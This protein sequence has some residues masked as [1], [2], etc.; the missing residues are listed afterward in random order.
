MI[1]NYQ[2]IRRKNALLTIEQ[3]NALLW[4]GRAHAN[5]AFQRIE[6]K[7]MQ[8]LAE[9]EHHVIGDVHHRIN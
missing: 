4:L 5:A 9:L 3:R 2:S 6:V 8:R 7:G 1:C